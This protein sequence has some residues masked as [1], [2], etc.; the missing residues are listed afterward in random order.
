MKEEIYRLLNQ[1]HDEKK[2]T[3]IYEFMKGLMGK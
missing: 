2:L 3:L 1:I